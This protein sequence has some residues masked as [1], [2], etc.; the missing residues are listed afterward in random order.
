MGKIRHRRVPMIHRAGE[1]LV[2][3]QGTP[4]YAFDLNIR[5]CP[6]PFDNVAVIV[7]HGLCTEM[8]Q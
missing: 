3:D 8:S 1:V 2:E 7:A 5:I 6:I 4:R